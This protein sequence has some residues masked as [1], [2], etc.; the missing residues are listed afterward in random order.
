M[1]KSSDITTSRNN[2]KKYALNLER[3]GE[4]SEVTINVRDM[5]FHTYTTRL[6]Q[7]DYLV[8]LIVNNVKPYEFTIDEDPILFQ[9]MLQY[10]R[11]P[12]YHPHKEIE[13]RFYELLH[14]YGVSKKIKYSNTPYGYVK[15]L[16]NKYPDVNKLFFNSTQLDSNDLDIIY[17]HGVDI[18]Y[19]CPNLYDNLVSQNYMC[20]VGF[21]Q[22]L[23]KYGRLDFND[24]IHRLFEHICSY[25]GIDHVLCMIK[26]FRTIC[27]DF[28]V[29]HYINIAI[30]NHNIHAYICIN[31]SYQIT[32]DEFK[33][34]LEH[35]Q[36]NNINCKCW[37]CRP[38]L[39]SNISNIDTPS[40]Y[41]IK[42]KYGGYKIGV[43]S[44]DI[45]SPIIL[46]MLHNSQDQGIYEI[47]LNDDHKLLEI[48]MLYMKYKDYVIPHNYISKIEA[49]MDKYQIPRKMYHNTELTDR[50]KFLLEQK[51]GN[52]DDAFVAALNYDYDTI[53]SIYQLGA[54]INYRCFAYWPNA[55]SACDGSFISF[56]KQRGRS[57]SDDRLLGNIY[58]ACHNSN[59]TIIMQYHLAAHFT[60]S[61]KFTDDV[62]LLI[63]KRLMNNDPSYLSILATEEYEKV[64]LKNFDELL[65][66]AICYH[67]GMNVYSLVSLTNIKITKEN[68]ERALI[69]G[70]NDTF[71]V[72]MT[73]Y[74]ENNNAYDIDQSVIDETLKITNDRVQKLQLA[75]KNGFGIANM[76]N[77]IQMSI[78]G[79]LCQ[80]VKSRSGS[81]INYNYFNGTTILN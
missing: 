66:H 23:H 42:S 25:G 64:I 43:N 61:I 8:D 26:I 38:L 11:Y 32:V 79:E 74:L 65:D 50:A 33:K 70:F 81:I 12:A 67:G 15:Y 9:L 39:W 47:V 37:S 56:L 20:S 34:I 2:Q 41:I 1:F 48:I 51:S 44:D 16:L 57:D 63:I 53:L 45:S 68:L 22:C 18:N 52:V 35:I 78:N 30:K 17:N 62:L 80:P 7:S 72:I 3:I 75:Q 73:L 46:N 14:K 77:I 76:S 69:M 6:I 28:D 71:Y 58:N 10:I 59:I 40:T 13:D 60:P 21:I 24:N 4:R 27:V 5:V 36:Q 49:L 19:Y 54:D 55:A 31:H 29:L